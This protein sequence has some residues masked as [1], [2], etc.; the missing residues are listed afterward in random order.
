MTLQNNVA[1]TQ[2]TH[3]HGLDDFLNP[4]SMVTPG[5]AGSLVMFLTNA[6]CYN[7]NLP[8]RWVGLG[9]SGMVGLLIF[10]TATIP[11]WQKLVY[12]ILNSLIIFAVGMGTANLAH[13]PLLTASGASGSPHAY[14]HSGIFDFFISTASAQE[15]PLAS[16][17]IVAITNNGNDPSLLNIS[18]IQRA[19]VSG[20]LSGTNSNENVLQVNG[21]TPADTNYGQAPQISST[22]N[23]SSINTSNTNLVNAEELAHLKA[24]NALLQSQ[25]Q[26]LQNQLRQQQYQKN[27]VNAR[28]GNS[29]FRAW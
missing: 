9:L 15:F 6:L 3:S 7:F 20:S 11:F 21:S 22:N 17:N 24:Q 26:M 5:V 8:T 12:Y 28:S 19:N 1:P 27:Q 25:N 2:A 18:N 16:T 23:S 10:L 14:N 13:Q 29:F 4:K